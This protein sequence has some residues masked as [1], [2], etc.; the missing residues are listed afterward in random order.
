MFKIII[1]NTSLIF[2]SQQTINILLKKNNKPKKNPLL[3]FN[4]HKII[5]KSIL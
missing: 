2:Q 4:I 3:Y 5:L 1:S